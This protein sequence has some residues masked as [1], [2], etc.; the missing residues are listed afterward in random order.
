MYNPNEPLSEGKTL[1]LNLSVEELTLIVGAMQVPSFLGF[2]PPS[3]LPV[4]AAQA[5]ERSLRLRQLAFGTADGKFTVDINLARLLSVCAVPTHML[6]I[7]QDF[8]RPEGYFEKSYEG[9]MLPRL[10]FICAHDSD[11][12]YQNRAAQGIHTF[13][14]MSNAEMVKVTLATIL[15]LGNLESLPDVAEP[16]YKVDHASLL[17]AEGL[18]KTGGA[19]AVYDRLINDLNAPLSLARALAS[20][21]K[22]LVGVVW[23]NDWQEP[24]YAYSE[25]TMLESSGYIVIPAEEGG[26]WAYHLEGDKPKM[27]VF[28]AVSGVM[29]VDE[30]VNRLH[31]QMGIA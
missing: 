8:A 6:V 1:I 20:R 26:V 17:K 15:Q 11:M 24:G 23:R 4:A 22:H 29:L 31:T 16:T 30:M 12:V 19:E 18:Y 13:A 14:T 9:K 2:R 5:A 7:Q 3:P 25:D 28:E 27:A 21:K 10:H